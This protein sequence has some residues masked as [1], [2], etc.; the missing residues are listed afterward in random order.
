MGLVGMVHP[1]RSGN[2]EEFSLT[3]FHE[4][5]GDE[6]VHIGTLPALPKQD[7]GS[8]APQGAAEFALNGWDIDGI[9]E[10][11]TAAEQDVHRG[12]LFEHLPAEVIESPSA[13]GDAAV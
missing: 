9:S 11:R 12:M 2:H 3:L 8:L 6:V 10:Q 1:S 13:L 7:Y 5:P 4:V